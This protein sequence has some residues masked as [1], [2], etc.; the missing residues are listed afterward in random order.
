M[1]NRRFC[2]LGLLALISLMTACAQLPGFTRATQEPAA[3]TQTSEVTELSR[4][5]TALENWEVRRNLAQDHAANIG[6]SAAVAQSAP[7][8]LACVKVPMALKQSAHYTDFGRL[9]EAVYTTA[10]L[11]EVDRLA[12]AQATT[13]KPVSLPTQSPPAAK[14]APKKK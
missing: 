2:S 9:M 8:S 3:V 11:Y 7:K 12:K 6:R 14:A 13:N 1:Y 10:C 4:R 5:V